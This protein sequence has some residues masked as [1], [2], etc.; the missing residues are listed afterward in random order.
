MNVMGHAFLRAT[1]K[2]RPRVTCIAVHLHF[3]NTTNGGN[4]AVRGHPQIWYH[5]SGIRKFEMH[6]I[7][8]GGA[9]Y[10]ER[11]L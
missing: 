10:G 3:C 1:T 9:F 7:T 11:R 5:L 2:M 6:S 8:H 4:A